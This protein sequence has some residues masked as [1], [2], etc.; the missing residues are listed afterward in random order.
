ML[1]YIYRE[2][3]WSLWPCRHHMRPPRQLLWSPDTALICHLYS[4][5]AIFVY[6]YRRL[7]FVSGPR[8]D[9]IIPA[10]PFIK[11]EETFE[12]YINEFANARCLKKGIANQDKIM[13]SGG[14]GW[15]SG[16]P[17]RRCTQVEDNICINNKVR[18]TLC[19]RAKKNHS[20]IKLN[21]STIQL[22]AM[23]FD[24]PEEN[25]LQEVGAVRQRFHQHIDRQ[26]RDYGL[27]H[28]YSAPGDNGGR[29]PV[30]AALE[31]HH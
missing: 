12:R 4:I 27:E 7:N 23:R 30:L 13:W 9:L 21:S 16:W 1:I 3:C 18:P 24:W 14:A 28:G 6:T 15:M 2:R 26:I 25:R 8:I 5:G 11:R 17:G 10:A 31:Q 29:L 22:L 20:M 19:Q